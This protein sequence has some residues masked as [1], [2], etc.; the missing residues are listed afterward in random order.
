[1]SSESSGTDFVASAFKY[2]TNFINAVVTPKTV[3]FSE[4]FKISI[5]WAA[6]KF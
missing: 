3:I 5:F 6:S 2:C 1:M 4:Y